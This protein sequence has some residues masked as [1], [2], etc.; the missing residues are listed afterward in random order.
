MELSAGLANVTLSDGTIVRPLDILS[1]VRSTD[2]LVACSLSRYRR[3][4]FDVVA[5]F[6]ESGGTVVLITDSPTAPLVALAIHILAT[7]TT[8]SA[9]GA[10]RR[11]L[12][13]DRLSEDLGLLP[14][15]LRGLPQTLLMQP[16][17]SSTP[18][19][20][21]RRHAFCCSRSG[22]VVSVEPGG[23]YSPPDLPRCRLRQR[24]RGHRRGR[25]RWYRRSGRHR[26]PPA[27]QSVAA[28]CRP[29]R[30]PPRR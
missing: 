21:L 29:S 7:L 10:A 5:P 23:G 19:L 22:E 18:H 6:R 9:K 17:A 28:P 2:V 14:G 13:R 12:E 24:R 25:Q 1:D 8:A 4:T 27:R 15:Q 16:D 30:H 3:Y 26:T 11:Q 20:R